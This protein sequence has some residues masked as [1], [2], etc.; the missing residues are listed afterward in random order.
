M[1]VSYEVYI[2]FNTFSYNKNSN[3]LILLFFT[4]NVLIFKE[5]EK[6]YQYR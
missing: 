3:L 1:R 2:F 4:V 5:L 6:V